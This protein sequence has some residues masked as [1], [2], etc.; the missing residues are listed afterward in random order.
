M[1]PRWLPSKGI[2]RFKQKLNYLLQM[3]QRLVAIKGIGVNDP[4]RLFQLSW[5]LILCV[6]L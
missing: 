5:S 2:S 1:I 4:Q 6:L 3:L